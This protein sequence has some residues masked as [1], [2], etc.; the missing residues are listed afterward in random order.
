MSIF[1]VWYC[2]GRESLFGGFVSKL[3]SAISL[4]L[5]FFQSRPDIRTWGEA[6]LQDPSV[7]QRP[8][9][10]P[11]DYGSGLPGYPRQSCAYLHGTS[12][13]SKESPEFVSLFTLLDVHDDR[14]RGPRLTSFVKCN[15]SFPPL[16]ADKLGSPSYDFRDLLGYRMDY[17]PYPVS[18]FEVTTWKA[19]LAQHRRS[20]LR[21]CVSSVVPR[22]PLIP[23]VRPPLLMYTAVQN[24]TMSP[25][26]PRRMY[27]C[28]NW[29][30]G[31]PYGVPAVEENERA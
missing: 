16:P 22:A 13:H 3:S 19:V 10:A 18:I 5:G 17:H 1:C 28:A 9:K 20:T 14:L 2:A 6:N 8:E 15:V 23:S 7:Q 24:A 4:P 30:V 11:T 27:V 29:M 31:Y 26:D 21:N 25:Q 12:G